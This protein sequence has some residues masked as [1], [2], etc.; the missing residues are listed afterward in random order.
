MPVGSIAA[1]DAALALWVYNPRLFD[2]KT[3]A[4]AWGFLHF[5]GVL[6]T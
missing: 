6:F 2:S 4:A 3:V 1:R 5:A